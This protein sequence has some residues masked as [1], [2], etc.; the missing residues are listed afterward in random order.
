MNKPVSIMVA[1]RSTVDLIMEIDQFSRRA[2]KFKASDSCF[3]VGG[4]GANASIAIARFG[5]LPALIT[6]LGDDMMGKF[7]HQSLIN[8]SVDLSMSVISS[9][10]QSSVSAAF[11]DR[12]GERQTFNFPG[13][14]FSELPTA[15]NPN[16]RPSAVL[17]DNRHSELTKWAI[18]IGRRQNLPIVIDAEAP[19]AVEDIIGATHLAFS[20]QGLESFFPGCNIRTAL[21]QAQI[22]TGCWVCVTDGEN[23][24]WFLQDNLLD[25]IPA[26]KIKTVDTVGAG[27]VWHGVF[28]LC[29]AEE[30]GEMAAI[31]TANAAA[32]MKCQNF[33]GIAASPDRQAC[34]TFIEEY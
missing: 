31:K 13:K 20:R 30:M 7:I 10:A 18:E 8:E 17:A 4:P 25:N 3:V 21:Q 29:L 22:E 2:E 15:L 32:A 28:T 24:V 9:E 16:F 23:G 34:L 19:F 33:G 27:D 14:G 11:V 6:F 12:K 5:G 1:G 26:F